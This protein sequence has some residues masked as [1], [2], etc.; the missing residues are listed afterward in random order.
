MTEEQE[1]Y[2]EK[3]LCRYPEINPDYQSLIIA[4]LKQEYQSLIIALLE[5]ELEKHEQKIDRIK[6][7]MRE[8]GI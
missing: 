6:A 1:K 2:Y 7:F 5:Q 8:Y 4:L 3:A